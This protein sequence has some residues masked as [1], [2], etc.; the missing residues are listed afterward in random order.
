[1]RDGVAYLEGEVLRESTR[2]R[3]VELA[4]FVEGVVAVETDLTVLE[5]NAEEDESERGEEEESSG[6]TA[7]AGSE[8]PA[9]PAAPRRADRGLPAEGGAGRR[10]WRPVPTRPSAPM[11]WR[12]SRTRTSKSALRRSRSRTASSA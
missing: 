12:L 10:Q 9:P 2:A 11:W 4:L 8:A 7:A 6:R 3:V 1:M 5:P